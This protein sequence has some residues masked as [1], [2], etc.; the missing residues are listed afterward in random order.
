MHLYLT[1]QYSW[2]PTKISAALLTITVPAAL[3]PIVGELTS[4]QGPRWWST[5]AFAICGAAF[6]SFGNVVGPSGESQTLF[7]VHSVVIG[8]SLAI[9]VNSNQVAIS[10][11]AQ[12]YGFA[13]TRAEDKDEDLGQILS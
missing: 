11:A 5:C 9:L 1:R 7:I 12:G 4:R 10:V 13:R 2:T 6:I 3:N 8:V